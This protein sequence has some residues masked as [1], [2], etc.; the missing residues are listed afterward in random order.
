MIIQNGDIYKLGDHVLGCGSS[1][2]KDFVD[3]VIGDKKIRCVICDPPYGIA[4]V[5]GKRYLSKLGV[6]NDKVI[7][8][9]QLQSDDEYSEFTKKYLEIIKPHL[10][11]YNACY[12]FGADSM[13]CAL[14]EGMDKADFYC[15]QMLIWVKD[16]VVLGR[17]DYLPMHE[18]IAYGWHGRHKMERSKAKSVIFHPKPSRSKLHE[19]QKPVGLI[20]KL[21]PNSTKTGEW[22]F[23]GF[24]G[25]GSTMIACEHLGRRCCMIELS[26][27]YCAT[28]IAR[29]EKLTN[30][31]TE[32]LPTV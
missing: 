17:K 19:T 13:F 9:D 8:G 7:I 11:S 6:G 22:V 12:I 15:S 20:R 32:K 25:G 23:D 18:L 26:V 30:L 24:G 27:D 31:K 21:I 28:I 10:T 29:W 16:H 5:E 1:T 14:R 2:D 3:K 4:Y